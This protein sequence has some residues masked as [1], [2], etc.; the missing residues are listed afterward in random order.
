MDGIGG[1]SVECAVSEGMR[2]AKSEYLILLNGPY[3]TDI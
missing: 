1:N 2:E 3:N